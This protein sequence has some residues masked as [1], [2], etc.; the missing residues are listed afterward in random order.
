MA[1]KALLSVFFS[2]LALVI[3]F[4]VF[5]AQIHDFMML[6]M[7]VI[8]PRFLPGLIT[9]GF[10]IGFFGSVLS[11]LSL[12]RRFKLFFVEVDDGIMQLEWLS[13]LVLYVTILTVASLMAY[14][15][16]LRG[17]VMMGIAIALLWFHA[18]S[19]RGVMLHQPPGS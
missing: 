2:S 7:P 15:G 3:S 6:D 11:L 12:L 17:F 1:V 4:C 13:L 14:C 10:V 5:L 18:K 9:L 16:Q 8:I 19:F